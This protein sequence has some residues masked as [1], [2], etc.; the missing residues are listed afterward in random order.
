MNGII[1]VSMLSLNF[2]SLEC[3]VSSL[4]ILLSLL[5]TTSDRCSVSLV[6]SICEVHLNRIKTFSLSVAKCFNFHLE[7]I[8]NKGR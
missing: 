5:T 1:A 4:Q 2:I 8:V 3:I 7:L 6:E